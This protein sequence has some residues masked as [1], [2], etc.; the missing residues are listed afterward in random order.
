MDKMYSFKALEGKIASNRSKVF[1]FLSPSKIVVNFQSDQ[2]IEL[3]GLGGK[4]R[5]SSI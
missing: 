4:K 2:G 1:T 5:V 3:G